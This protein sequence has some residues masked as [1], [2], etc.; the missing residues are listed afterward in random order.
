VRDMGAKK[1]PSFWTCVCKR[2]NEEK[3]ARCGGCMRWR[4]GKRPEALHQQDKVHNGSWVC[5]R[6]SRPN[7]KS[8]V[9]C[10]GCQRWRDGMRPDMRKGARAARAAA[11][12]PNGP[13]QFQMLSVKH[14]PQLPPFH[15][16]QMTLV[17]G[18]VAGPVAQPGAQPVPQH[19]TLLVQ[20]PIN[21]I[22]TIDAARAIQHN[23]AVQ[24]QAIPVALPAATADRDKTGVAWTCQ[25]CTCDNLATELA[26]KICDSP[27]ESWV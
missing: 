23:L 17:T 9:R 2:Q 11:T 1:K 25:K 27:R 22:N 18:S 24:N 13:Q 3:K 20:V 7:K 4:G 12:G 10:G 6:C 8:K 16:P 21:P 5:E 14:A 26:C 19:P 15:I